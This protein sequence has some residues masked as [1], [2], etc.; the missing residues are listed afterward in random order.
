MIESSNCR[1][2]CISPR[3]VGAAAITNQILCD[4]CLSGVTISAKVEWNEN[5]HVSSLLDYAQ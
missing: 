1:E 3:A 2:N 5:K 4:V